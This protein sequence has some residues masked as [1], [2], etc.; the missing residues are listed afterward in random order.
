MLTIT[1]EC[2]NCNACIDECPNNAIYN[3][4]DEYAIDGVS[5]PPLSMD[6]TYIVNDMCKMCEGYS[7]EP[8]CISVCPSDAVLLN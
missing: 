8:S 6:Y 2:I 5:Y 3:A 1:E 7:A 4:G